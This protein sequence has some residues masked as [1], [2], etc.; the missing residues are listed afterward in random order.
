MTRKIL[1]LFSLFT[2]ALAAASFAP[3]Q[4]TAPSSSFV[5]PQAAEKANAHED[6][7]YQQGTQALNDGNFDDAV[8]K[9]D[10]VAKMR[11]RKA[12]A[13]LYWKAYA[14]KNAG[15]KGQALATIAE[16]KKN[17]PQ[18]KYVDDAKALGVELSGSSAD[19]ESLSS[20]EEKLLALN[21]I[22]QNDPEKG[23]AYAEKWIQSNPSSKVKDRVLFILSQSSSDKAQQ[24][25]L[26]LAK[27]SNDVEVQKRAIRSLGMNCSSRNRGALKEIYMS[28]SSVEIKKAVFQGWLMCGDKEDVLAVAQ[29][30]KSPELRKE[31]IRYLGIM[32][33]H[34]ELRQLY[35]QQQSGD[36][37]IKEALLQAMGIGGDVQGLIGV[38]QTEKDPEVRR[39]AVKSLGIFG[40]QE[41]SNALLAIY[42]SQADLETKRE[43]INALFINGAGKQ[44][45]ALA[46]KET[47]PELK[48]ALVQKMS[49]MS[50]PEITEYMMEI[51]NK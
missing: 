40:G 28:S 6:E 32:G 15:N 44:M 19:P 7:L 47:N 43:V 21:A 30:E 10:Q 49:L 12:D 18:S 14:L 24:A 11:G 27:S 26:S 46:R 33:G 45:V 41:G 35:Q 3:A 31:A 36:L 2:L 42:G 16:L 17:Y 20:D 5:D 8:A 50:S 1:M 23:I 22:M 29:Q 34:T 37:E 39:R 25:L 38:A 13:A 48:R 9:F 51:L 4:T